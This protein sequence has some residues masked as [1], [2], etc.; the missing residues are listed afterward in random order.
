MNLFAALCAPLRGHGYGMPHDASLD[1]WRI[2]DLINET[3]VFVVLLFVIMVGWMLW[4]VFRHGERHQA[5]FDHGSSRRSIAVALG[6]A[7][8][9]FFVVD[10]HLFVNSYLAWTDVFGNFAGAES[11]PE[12]VRI[13]I[14]AH[15]WAWIARYAGPDGKFNTPDDIV[16]LNDIVIPQG[17][18][19]IMQLASTDVIHSF[20]VP[21][22]RAK[23]DVVPGMINRLLFTPKE[24]GEFDIACAQHCGANHYKMKGKLTVLPR[25]DFERWAAEAS[26]NAARA[27]DAA[28]EDAHWGWDWTAHSR[29]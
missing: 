5:H 28:D 21:N 15:Q 10:G 23:I 12:A 1:G 7:G 13:E 11:R 16:M 14:N 25:A 6:I 20:N 18:P 26:A 3:S 9:I 29:I 24:T 19:I 17:A 22:M 4:A 27:Y 2:D 8:A